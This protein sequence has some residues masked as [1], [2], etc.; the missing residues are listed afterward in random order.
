MRRMAVL[1]V[2]ARPVAA[3]PGT[4]DIVVFAQAARTGAFAIVRTVRCTEVP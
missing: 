2:C 3:P 4:N 1:G